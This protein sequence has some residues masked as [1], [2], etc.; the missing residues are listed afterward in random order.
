MSLPDDPSVP[1]AGVLRGLDLDSLFAGSIGWRSPVGTGTAWEPP[2][3]EE[4]ALLFPGYEITGLLGRGGM[5][6]VYGA[7]QLELD[8]IVAVKLLPAEMSEDATF[9]DRFRG[10][11][12]MLAQLQHPHIVNVFES[13]ATAAA[14]KSSAACAG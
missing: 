8:R 5:G 11:A 14:R 1:P 13:G 2:P 9:V 12:R 4:L 10:E 7:R 3:A 6:A